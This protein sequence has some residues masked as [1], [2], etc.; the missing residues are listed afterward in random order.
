MNFYNDVHDRPGGYPYESIKPQELKKHVNNA[1]FECVREFIIP[2]GLGI[3]G[4]GNNE[5]V[6]RR[7]GK[8]GHAQK[9]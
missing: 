7:K 8:Q 4:S 2:P 6:L 9:S 3:L 1:G 5:F